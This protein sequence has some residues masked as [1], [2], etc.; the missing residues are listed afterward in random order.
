MDRWRWVGLAWS[1]QLVKNTQSRIW[2]GREEKLEVLQKW[3][4]MDVPAIAVATVKAGRRTIHVT[5]ADSDNMKRSKARQHTSLEMFNLIT[6][7]RCEVRS[8]GWLPYT[9][10]IL[11]PWSTKCVNRLEDFLYSSP[12]ELRIRCWSNPLVNFIDTNHIQLAFYSFTLGLFLDRCPTRALPGIPA[13]ESCSNVQS[14]C[15][16]GPLGYWSPPSQA[17][18]PWIPFQKKRLLTQVAT[19]AHNEIV[20]YLVIKPS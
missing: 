19:C 13:R 20:T 14:W 10:F 12:L 16:F 4:N 3:I 11:P 17:A 6:W 2:L 5:L 9:S 7:E 18:Y 8:L 15:P 1:C